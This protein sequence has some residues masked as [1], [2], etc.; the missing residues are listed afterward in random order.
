MGHVPLYA[1][2]NTLARAASGLVSKSRSVV[3]LRKTI[4]PVVTVYLISC[5]PMRTE[6]LLVLILSVTGGAALASSGLEC[7]DMIQL[8][9]GNEI[10][11]RLVKS[12]RVEPC[13]SS[14]TLEH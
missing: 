6:C 5:P 8:N 9:P 3:S 1:V 4:V 11:A 12:V 14:K 7:S 10:H 13:T 2:K